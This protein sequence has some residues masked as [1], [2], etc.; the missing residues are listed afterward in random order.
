MSGEPSR[1]MAPVVS[2]VIPTYNRAAF[3]LETL[4]SVFA[5]SF[6]AY[7]VI[8]VNDGSPDDTAARLH[9]L[10]EAGRIVYR[11]QRNAGQSTARNRGFAEARGEFIAFLDDD[12]LWPPDKLAWQVAA[13]REHPDWLLVSGLAAVMDADGVRREPDEGTGEVQMQSIEAIFEGC[14]I[15]SPGQVLIRRAAL[16]AAGGFD[17][18]LHGCEDTDLWMRV[19][20]R[21][22]AAL[23]R[24]TA[25]H[26]R[27]HATNATRAAGRMFWDSVRTVRK[28]L[29]LVPRE[30][31]ADARR[32]ALRNAYF[33]AGN[34]VV[35][36]AR[37]GGL[38]AG[39]RAVRVLAYLLPSMLGDAELARMIGRDLLPARVRAW[40]RAVRPLPVP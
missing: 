22:P 5:Q 12:D 27:V 26:Y 23:V 19:A 39:G 16:E 31:R 7:E 25:L 18:A 11:E 10:A 32:H 29:P 17:P 33:C 28:N 2:V 21:G 4:G 24:R 14:A 20:A 35:G 30:R 13:L 34:R 6:T 15:I 38:R 3:L 37:D 9:P 36:A 40:W 8:V 1:A